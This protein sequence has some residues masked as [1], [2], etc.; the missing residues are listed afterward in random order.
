M[1]MASELFLGPDGGPYVSVNENSGDIEL[2]DNSGN[3]VAFWDESNTQW[4]FKTNDIQNVGSLGADKLSDGIA[5]QGNS[6]TSVSDN[7]GEYRLAAAVPVAGGESIQITSSTFTRVGGADDRVR[8]DLTDLAIN[9]NIVSDVI[10][11][12][13]AIMDSSSDEGTV[14]VRD[15]PATE[16]Q[17]TG[18]GGL[19]SPQEPYG[20][21]ANTLFLEARLDSGSA[22]TLNSMSIQI[23]EQIA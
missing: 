15:T 5:G 17:N 20:G 11:S 18:F 23:W 4:D 16:V 22:I 1:G 21:T 19:D 12:F 13:S 7:E 14:R 6:I 8:V 2:K 9:T 10:V 3:V